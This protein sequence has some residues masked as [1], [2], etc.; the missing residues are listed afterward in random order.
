MISIYGSEYFIVT[1]GH[2]ILAYKAW[3]SIRTRFCCLVKANMML[4]SKR[5]S[6]RSAD[7]LFTDHPCFIL[8]RKRN[9]FVNGQIMQGERSGV[10]LFLLQKLRPPSCLFTSSVQTHVFMKI[11]MTV[12]MEIMNA[13]KSS[14]PHDCTWRAL[15]TAANQALLLFSC[16][17]CTNLRHYQVGA[18]SNGLSERARMTLIESLHLCSMNIWMKRRTRKTK[19]MIQ[20]PPS[21]VLYFSLIIDQVPPSPSRLLFDLIT[22]VQY[23]TAFTSPRQLRLRCRFTRKGDKKGSSQVTR[24]GQENSNQP[25][26]EKFFF[27]FLLCFSSLYCL[28]LLFTFYSLEHL[29]YT[30]TQLLFLESTPHLTLASYQ[31][32]FL[33]YYKL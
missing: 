1:L 30:T 8:E 18:Y 20:S 15:I 32:R 9:P 23:R 10:E 3:R 22:S 21:S 29:T 33:I 5:Y 2:Y 14:T 11:E 19:Y 16:C 17:S 25:W 7:L 27:K 12:V 28:R 31:K 4:W 13:V 6:K 24:F 26:K